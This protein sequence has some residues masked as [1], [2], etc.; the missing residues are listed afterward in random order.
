M[1]QLYGFTVAELLVPIGKGIDS[2]IRLGAQLNDTE[3]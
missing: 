2:Y 1:P 3:W